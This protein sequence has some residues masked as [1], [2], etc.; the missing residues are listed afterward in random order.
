MERAVLIEVREFFQ[1]P[2]RTPGILPCAKRLLRFND[3]D[4]LASDMYKVLPSTST[5]DKPYLTVEDG[6]LI[7]V[8]ARRTSRLKNNELVNNMVKGGSEIVDHLADTHSK[9][10]WRSAQRV[11]SDCQFPGILVEID[12]GFV[13]ASVQKDNAFLKSAKLLPCSQSFS[14]T[15]RN[16]SSIRRPS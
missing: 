8:G 15:P 13:R 6:E 11:D 5:I 9:H 16:G 10:E 14:L 3:L 7:F 4:G 12:S 1:M 2:K